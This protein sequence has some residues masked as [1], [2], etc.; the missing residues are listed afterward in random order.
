MSKPAVTN[1][2]A[3]AIILIAGLSLTRPAAA[4]QGLEPCAEAHAS[5]IDEG[6][7]ICDSLW[8][9]WVTVTTTCV[10]GTA[11]KVSITCHN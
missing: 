1:V 7:A 5:A 3:G 11:V 2:F 9:N 6:R 8:Y 10:G 4:D